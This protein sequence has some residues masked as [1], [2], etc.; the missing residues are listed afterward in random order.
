MQI[1]I[2][3][4]LSVHVL[5]AVFWMATTGA[6][7][8]SGG[9]GAQTLFPRQMDAIALVV[10]T[11]GYLW[12]ALHTGGFGSYEW[13]LA[14]GAALAIIAALIQAI[15]VGVSMGKLQTEREAALKRITL[16][17]RLASPLLGL[18][19]LCMVVARFV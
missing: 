10:L 8:R 13:V 15:G 9:L 5:A 4:A 18:G 16:C 3:L 1:W 6:L 11:G 7:A 12:S 2:I 17:H 14:S 19:L